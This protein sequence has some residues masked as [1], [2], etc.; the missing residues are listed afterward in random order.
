MLAT[1]QQMLQD[2]K[3]KID[4]IRMQIIKVT[5]TNGTPEDVSEGLGMY[6][7]WNCMLEN[8]TISCNFKHLFANFVGI[9]NMFHFVP[10]P[11][12]C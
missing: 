5:R 12:A 9:Q 6:K 7:N 3:I 1:A 11:C 8:V 2:S 4:I 10:L